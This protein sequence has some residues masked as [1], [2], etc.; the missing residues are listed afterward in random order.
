L[1]N[2]KPTTDG[3]RTVRVL[4]IGDET[5]LRY[6]EWV[7]SRRQLVSKLSGGRIGY[8]HIPDTSQG[9]AEGFTRA[10]NGQVDKE[11]L[12]VDERNNGGGNLPWFFVEKLARKSQ[13]LIQQRHGRDVTETQIIAGPKAMLINHNA[14]SG[15][16]M[17]PYLFSKAKLGPL[18]GTRTWGGLVGIAGSAPLVD[19]GFLTA[20]EFS[21][22]DPE[23]NEIVAENTGVDPDIQIDNTPDQLMSGRDPQLERAV[24]YLLGELKKLPARK[25]RKEIPVLNRKGRIGG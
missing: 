2:D 25:P 21:I 4:P 22:F 19:S 23:T 8:M 12:V 7:E 13:T 15:G 14:G 18:V 17:L 16:D 11:A 6:A 5:L 20:P 24:E 1:I 10:F 3:A 9:G